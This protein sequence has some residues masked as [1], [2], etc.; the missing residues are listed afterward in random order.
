MTPNSH[1]SAFSSVKR[2]CNTNLPS[3]EDCAIKHMRHLTKWLHI[4]NQA[5][6]PLT[7][8]PGPS[9]IDLIISFASSAQTKAEAQALTF[10]TVTYIRLSALPAFSLPLI[11]HLLINKHNKHILSSALGIQKQA[12]ENLP[13]RSSWSS[14]GL[15]E[16]ER[17]STKI[18]KCY[19]GRKSHH[20]LRLNCWHVITKTQDFE[21]EL[22]SS[23]LIYFQER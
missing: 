11:F 5:S 14:E 3:C 19:S 15:G 7:W 13:S 18:K 4:G 21:A 23:H 12:D 16:K 9:T 1:Y 10:K 8:P 20:R 22:I 6:D 17:T 2:G